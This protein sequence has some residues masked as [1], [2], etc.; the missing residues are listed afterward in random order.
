MSRGRQFSLFDGR[1]PERAHGTFDSIPKEEG[2]PAAPMEESLERLPDGGS[3]DRPVPVSTL[4]AAARD[5]LEATFAPLWVL[6]EVTNWS[7]AASGHRYFSLRDDRAQIQCV[8]FQGDA[9]RLP[10]D[11]EEGMEVTAF[12]RVSLYPQRGR[13]QLIVREIQAKGEGLWRLAFERLRRKL[14]DE[15]LLDPA[16]KRALPRVPRRIGIVTSRDGAALRDILTIVKRRAPWTSVLVRDCR[17]QGEGAGGDIRAALEVLGSHPGVDLIILTRGG[18]SVED[19]WCFNEEGVARAVA[20]CP[21]PVIS[22]V[23]H[24]VDVTIVDL[25]ADVRAPTPSAAAELAVPDREDLRTRV[26]ALSA[27]LATGLRRRARDGATRASRFEERLK[28]FMRHRLDR[29]GGR[30]L[31]LAER[32]NALSPL[33]TL[34]RGYAV[35]LAPDGRVLRTTDMF[36]V[37][38]EFRLRVSDG[39]VHSRSERVEPHDGSD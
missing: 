27:G 25:V 8:L 26:Q 35:P 12:G 6:G 22:A 31:R 5:L 11:P 30:W 19:L 39:T 28:A 23:G 20:A 18:G 38:G 24:E 10:T 4:N 14:Q 9:W 15:G 21:I 32:L 7:V 1:A 33:H 2:A 37:G 3:A 34:R 29:D 13:Y 17:V 36:E 16:R